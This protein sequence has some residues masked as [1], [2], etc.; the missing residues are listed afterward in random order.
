MAQTVQNLPAAWDTWVRSLGWED[1]LEKGTATHS[2]FLAC[3]I[4]WIE[5]PGRQQSMQRVGHFHF[6]SL[7]RS[8]H[9]K[10]STII[11]M[12]EK[13]KS[14]FS[15]NINKNANLSTG[16]VTWGSPLEIVFTALR[17]GRGEVYAPVESR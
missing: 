3:R 11:I 8:N 4:P 9:I 2:S 10:I 5:E 12:I 1:P 16:I 14:L 13:D 17:R 7:S 15:K 6:H